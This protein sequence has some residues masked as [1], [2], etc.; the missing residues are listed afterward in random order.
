M[1]TTDPKRLAAR[2]LHGSKG[3]QQP[4]DLVTPPIVPASVYF[5]P[6]DPT[7]PHQY[8]RWSN[9]T[10]SALEDALAIIED[11][12]TVAFPSGMA[13][14]ASI[15]YALLRSGDRILLPSDGYYTT[16][17]LAEK[18]LVPMGVVADTCSTVEYATKDLNGY[19]LVWVETPSN[20]GL[21]L[22]DLRCVAARARSAGAIVVADNTTPS[23][24]GQRPFDLGA[25]MLISSDTKSVSGHSDN[26]LGHVSS[27]RGDLLGSVREWRKLSGAIPGAFETWIGHRGLQSLEVRFDRMCSTAEIVA[28]RL[29]DH[30]AVVEVRYPGLP[31]H[32]QHT[33]AKSQ[34]LRFGFLLGVTFK[35]KDAAE[36]FIGECSVIKPVTSF[37]GVRT[38]A[39]RRARWGD[40]VA[41]GFVR[42]SIGVEVS[43]VLWS[44]MEKT[45]N[46]L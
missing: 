13:A 46:A 24:F 8:G 10:W 44:E 40:N 27:R 1:E 29:A 37:G 34:M 45:L 12:E 20:P 31:T 14:I 22:C 33:L 17:A 19:K 4:G 25:D 16:R 7:A 5:L 15:F 42:L 28:Q 43:D 39:E 35:S 9:P 21:D 6:G 32:P 38:S 41:A 36:R 3:R 18:F 2:A 30:P 26:L 23:A 11:A